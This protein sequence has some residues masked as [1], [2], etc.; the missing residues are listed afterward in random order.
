MHIGSLF[1]GGDSKKKAASV[2]EQLT[3]PLAAVTDYVYFD[4]ALVRVLNGMRGQ[5]ISLGQV[6]FGLYG[7]ACP[8]A[9]GRFLEMIDQGLYE[10]TSFYR[11][12]RDFSAQAGAYEGA[13]SE[14]ASF[15]R[16]VEAPM[17]EP[18][19]V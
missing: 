18:G 6:T 16:G 1:G 14:P 13:S 3:T 7:D 15:A 8:D 9:V 2:P 12:F 19:Y 5:P 17:N 10:E 11:I 4:L